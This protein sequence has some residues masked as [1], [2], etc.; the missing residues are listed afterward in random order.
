[1]TTTPRP[2]LNSLPLLRKPEVSPVMARLA[3]MS[4]DAPPSSDVPAAS[5]VPRAV[6]HLTTSPSRRRHSDDYGGE[7]DWTVVAQFRGQ[8]SA[9]LTEISAAENLT[10]AEQRERGAQIIKDLLDEDARVALNAGTSVRDVDQEE[11]MAEAIFDA[12]FRLGRFQPF[13]EDERVENIEVYGCDSVLLEDQDG[14]LREGPPVAETDRELEEFLAFIGSR[15]EANARAFSEANPRLHLRLDS[16]ERLAAV[17][18]VTPRPQVVIRRHRL[19]EVTLADLIERGT[20]SP[21]QANFLAAAIRAQKSIVVVGEQGAGKTTL[22]RALCAEIPP[23]ERI[24]TFETEYELHLHELTNRHKRV[25]AFESRPGT[26]ERGIDGRQAG[27]ITLSDLIIDSFRFNISRL[28]VGEVRGPEVFAMVKA[29]QSGTGSISTTHAKNARMGIEK[30]VTCAME[31]GSHVTHDYAV[32]A[33]A[34]GID[35]IVYVELETSSKTSEASEETYRRRYV[36]EIMGVE[37]G[38]D[39]SGGYQVTDIFVPNPEGGPGRATNL[40]HD[41]AALERYGFNA[42]AF[43]REAGK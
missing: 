22:V 38:G 31:A 25:L 17:S 33:V 28:I 23:L 20:V 34:S 29:M 13:L 43:N 21:V 40:P 11:R 41:H 19:R 26:G 10:A 27:E 5:W 30:L 36:S 6:E 37:L 32:R 15:S 1:M 8:V 12:V 2:D 18:W 3:G 4:T 7:I 16:G 35:L 14:R 39:S 42:A 24:A 9:R